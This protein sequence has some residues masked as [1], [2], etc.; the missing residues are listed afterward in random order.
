MATDS[1][2]RKKYDISLLTE[3][4]T[5]DK[6]TLVGEYLTLAVTTPISFICQ[7][8]KEG[9]KK[10]R[11]LVDLGVLCKDCSI[12][13]GNEKKKETYKAKTGY[14]NPSQNPEIKE[15]KSEIYN[16]K[17]SEEKKTIYIKVS[18]TQLSK[19]EE[20]KAKKSK[21]LKAAWS[22]KSKEEKDAVLKKRQQIWDSKT[23]KEKQSIV[24]TREATTLRDHGVRNV[25][26]KEDTKRK[27]AQTLMKKIG[28]TNP[29]SSPEI[30][31]RICDTRFKTRGVYY[32]TQGLDNNET[33]KR[34]AARVKTCQKKYNCDNPMQDPKIYEKCMKTQKRK[35][36]YIMPS[37]D[38]R[39]I[40]G[41]EKYAIKDLLKITTEA[42]I[43]TNVDQIKYEYNGSIRRYTPDIKQPS[44]NKIIE[45]KSPWTLRCEPDK[46][47]A[48]GDACKA[49]GYAYEIW[50]YGDRGENKGKLINVIIY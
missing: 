25:F 29:F 35:Y 7:C 9:S 47:K 12:K 16:S 14:E 8:G 6:A 49:Q 34:M 26:L 11:S 50:V 22:S 30:R 40:M 21:K 15:I 2:K 32:P 37:G 28:F 36:S 31:S 3:C 19:S 27:I 43:I 18:N 38:V 13:K 5:R 4:I 44:L 39:Y 23:K 41:Y 17:S 10:F 33:Q 46:I 45:V 24:A 1:P 20:E 48:K 42:D